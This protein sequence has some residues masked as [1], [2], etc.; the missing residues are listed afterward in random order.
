VRFHLWLWSQSTLP[1]GLSSPALCTILIVH[2]S[3]DNGGEEA[4]DWQ[5][6]LVYISGAVEAERLLRIAYLVAENRLLR[7]QIKGRVHLSDA[8]RR[9]LSP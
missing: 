2:L 4:M 1:F 3:E 8:Q 6:L 7:G 5:Q 9:V